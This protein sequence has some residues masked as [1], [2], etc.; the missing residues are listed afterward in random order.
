MGVT[1][2]IIEVL[3]ETDDLGRT[4]ESGVATGELGDTGVMGGEL[5]EGGMMTGEPGV[6]VVGASE[7]W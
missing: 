5:G 1:G 4:G 7:W 3:G 2:E 6:G